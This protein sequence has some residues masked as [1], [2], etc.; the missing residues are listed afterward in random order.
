M[1]C[2]FSSRRRHTSCALVTGVQTCA[3]PICRVWVVPAGGDPEN[4]QEVDRLRIASPAGSDIVKGLDGLFRVRNGGILPDDPEARI[5]TRSLE[6]SNV[7]A[8]TPLVEMI[9]ASKRWDSTLRLISAAPERNSVVYGK[10]VSVRVDLGGRSSI[11]K[12]NKN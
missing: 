12:K 8:T 5:V 9:E 3:L 11:N 1:V 6:G 2:F 10:S 4:P 7:T